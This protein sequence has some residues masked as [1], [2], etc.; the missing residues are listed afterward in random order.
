MRLDCRTERIL[1][2]HL[3]V[4]LFWD[5]VYFCFF[6]I[7]LL[8]IGACAFVILFGFVMLAVWLRHPVRM[9]LDEENVVFEYRFLKPKQ[10]LIKDIKKLIFERPRTVDQCRIK[11]GLIQKASFLVEFYENGDELVQLTPY[12]RWDLRHWSVRGILC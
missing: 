10:V 6:S 1:E 7:F 3:V 8:I 4:Y 9:C 2:L 5:Q 12:S 11:Y